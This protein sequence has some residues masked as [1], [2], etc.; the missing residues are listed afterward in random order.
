MLADK[1]RSAASEGLS[2]VGGYAEYCGWTGGT[3]LIYLT[4]LSGGIGTTVRTGDLVLVFQSRGGDV[5]G[6]S[7]PPTPTGYT[8]IYGGVA[9]GMGFDIGWS[10]MYKKATVSDTSVSLDTSSRDN[11]VIVQ[12]WRA[13]KPTTPIPT[14][15]QT[16]VTNSA[17]PN[18]PAVTPTAAG[19]VVAVFG[20]NSFLADRITSLVPVG[21]NSTLSAIGSGTGIAA[22]YIPWVSGT[23]DPDT[24]NIDKPDNTDFSS[25][26]IS[27]VIDPA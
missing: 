21:L 16:A 20:A 15:N 10:L 18:P 1:L 4:N 7:I 11:A 13:Q 19:A 2:Y 3:S 6:S 9:S 5:S 27:V 12:V 22:G 24:F 17:R 25:V 14:G 26:G 8:S 23:V